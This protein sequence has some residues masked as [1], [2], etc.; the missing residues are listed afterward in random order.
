MTH[1]KPAKRMLNKYLGINLYLCV[2]HYEPGVGT[3]VSVE[4]PLDPLVELKLVLEVGSCQAG[5]DG[6]SG[7]GEPVVLEPASCHA[8]IV[9][10]PNGI[11]GDG[12][13]GIMGPLLNRSALRDLSSCCNSA[14]DCDWLSLVLSI[15]YE[16]V[17]N[18]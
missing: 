13:L 6:F 15:I 1:R 11:G 4:L 5:M 12:E 9:G 8:G 7:N 10:F 17:R 3:S 2:Q 16:R 18:Q 14:K